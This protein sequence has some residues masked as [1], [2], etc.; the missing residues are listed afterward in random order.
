MFNYEQLDIWKD[1]ILYAK[2]IYKLTC[3]FPREEMYG[4][5]NQLRRAV[6]SISSNIAEGSGATSLKDTVHYLDIAIKSTLETTSQ[7]ALALELKYISENE[8]EE[9]Y[10]YAEKI[11]RKM[12]AYKKYLAQKG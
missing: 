11:I 1:A 12:R 8:K 6:V 7:L 9:S 10:E 2:L 5:T 3:E 4:L